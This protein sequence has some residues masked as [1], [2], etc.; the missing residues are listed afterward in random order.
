[1]AAEQGHADAQH[2]LGRAYETGM[3]LAKDV[4]LAL[5]WYDRAAKE[6]HRIARAD[7]DRLLAQVSEGDAASAVNNAP[8]PPP[9]PPSSSAPPPPPSPSTAPPPAPDPAADEVPPLESESDQHTP[10]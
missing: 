3:G 1:M 4:Q 9:P 5:H 8:P 6:G 7:H 10:Q 2:N